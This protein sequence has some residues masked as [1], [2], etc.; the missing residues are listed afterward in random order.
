MSRCGEPFFRQ[1]IASRRTAW[2]SS[3]LASRCSTE[4]CELTA[5]GAVAREELERDQRRAAARRALVVEPAREQLD[6]LA[7]AELADRAVGD[8]PLAVVGAPGRPLDL[9]LPFAPEVG[10]LALVA[11]L[12]EGVGLGGCLGEGQASPFSERGAGPT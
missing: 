11:L 8:R 4:R 5:P 3:A 2:L 12:R 10:E 6:L 1:T 9:V 7:E